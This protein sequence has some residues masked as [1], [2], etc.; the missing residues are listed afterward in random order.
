MAVR[1]SS[2]QRAR[3]DPEPLSVLRPTLSGARLRGWRA[4]A[5]RGFDLTAVAITLPVALPV[6][7]AAALAI[8][9]I[10]RQRPFYGDERVGAGGR[11]FR[12]LKLRT[13]RNDPAILDRYFAA[14]PEVRAEYERTRKLD[15]DPRI[16]P[17][18][19][20]LRKTSLDEL[21][22][23]LNVLR[24]EMAIVGP[25]PL[26][27]NEFARRGRYRFALASVRPGMT[28]LWQVRGR[29]D[30]S[31][32]SRVLLD[33]VYVRRWSLFLDLRILAATPLVVVTGRGA[34]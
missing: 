5:K 7:A 32:E 1:D 17:L 9:A 31:P 16:T 6:L 21:P 2:Q 13:M 30:L 25:R 29:S 14:H 22:Q 28:G 26:S 24:G 11:P 8:A 27:P 4:A 15:E 12:C 10:D 20:L 34:R 18:G 3:T 19:R 33:H 23:I